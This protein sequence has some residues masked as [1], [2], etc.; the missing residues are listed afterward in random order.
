MAGATRPMSNAS[1]RAWAKARASR[2]A[3]QQT[4]TTAVA[5]MTFED[6]PLAELLAARENLRASLDRFPV[7]QPALSEWTIA[8]IAEI[9]IVIDA[10][11]AAV[12]E[13]GQRVSEADFYAA[14]LA[15]SVEEPEDYIAVV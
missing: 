4:E 5:S 11:E 13:A 15:R 12:D 2:K 1:M 6:M 8:K 7:S 9:S 10:K 3:T 14:E